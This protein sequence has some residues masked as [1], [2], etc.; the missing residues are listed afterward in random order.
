MKVINKG[1]WISL[2]IG[3]PSG[4]ISILIFLM[5]P[6]FLTGKGLATLALLGGYGYS[7]LGMLLVFPIMLWISGV[8][9]AKD[10][11]KMKAKWI[12][13][14]R[15]S[16]FVNSVIWFVFLAI[17]LINI[18]KEPLLFLGIIP[19]VIAAFIPLAGTPFTVGL[20]VYFL[21]KNRVDIGR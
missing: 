13:T 14:W 15:Y 10:L 21:I 7:I 1:G 20:I 5:I 6:S 18:Y 17:Y 19:I 4:L 8:I 16:F 3:L 12:I 11:L 9:M 2:L